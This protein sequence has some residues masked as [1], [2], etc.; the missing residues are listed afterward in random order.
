MSIDLE[1]YA[2]ALEAVE[3]IVSREPEADEVLRQTVAVL[4]ERIDHYAL[5]GIAFVEE[6][7]LVVGPTAGTGQ[8]GTIRI[9]V[10]IDYRGDTV[11]I[12]Q[13]D[14]LSAT[15]PEDPESQFLT[16]LAALISGHCLVGWDTGGEP[17]PEMP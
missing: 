8:A 9:E 16:Q 13:I 15:P 3:R 6:G 17:W 14:S 2:G 5:V 11:G 7:E 10:P 1:P 4:L 12:L